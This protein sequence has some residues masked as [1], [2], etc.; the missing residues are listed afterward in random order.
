M[1]DHIDE[2]IEKVSAQFNEEWEWTPDMLRVLAERA[3][4]LGTE[5]VEARRDRIR[6]EFARELLKG[7]DN[8]ADHGVNVPEANGW[9]IGKLREQAGEE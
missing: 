9:V 6:R 5:T 1:S 4:S 8:I 3:V 2:L 7:R